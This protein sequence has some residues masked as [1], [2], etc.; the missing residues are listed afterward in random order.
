[1]LAIR[2]FPHIKKITHDRMSRLNFDDCGA[3]CRFFSHGNI[4]VKCYSDKVAAF[5]TRYLQDYAFDCGIAP[6]VSPDIFKVK[7]VFKPGGWTYKYSASGDSK[8]VYESAT[9]RIYYCYLTELATPALNMDLVWEDEYTDLI[10]EFFGG[11]YGDMHRGNW[12]INELGDFV[13]IDFS[14]FYD[15]VDS[16]WRQQRGKRKLPIHWV[17]TM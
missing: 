17:N 7:A 9:K 2:D 11:T 16:P 13:I 10:E 6:A 1:M 5:K 12:G 4:G 15:S 3:E 8:R 14:H